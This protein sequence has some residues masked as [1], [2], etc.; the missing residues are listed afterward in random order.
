MLST[1]FLLAVPF[2]AVAGSTLL[3]TPAQAD[4]TPTP[5]FNYECTDALGIVHDWNGID[6]YSC[7]GWLDV[8]DANGNVMVHVKDGANATSTVSCVENPENPELLDITT[9]QDGLIGQGINTFIWYHSWIAG[10]NCSAA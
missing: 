6:P 2:L 10:N 9:E 5:P 7:V 4:I 3:A 8:F 1:K